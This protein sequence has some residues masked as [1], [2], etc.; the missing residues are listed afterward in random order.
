MNNLKTKSTS[1]SIYSQI[2][3]SGIPA[4]AVLLLIMYGIYSVLLPTVEMRYFNDKRETAKNLVETVY[5]GLVSRQKEV[6]AGTRT[7]KD[8]QYFAMQRIKM[9][10]YGKEKKDYFWLMDS[11]PSIIMHPYMTPQTIEQINAPS[12]NLR[13]D[14]FVKMKNAAMHKGGGFVDYQWQ[15]KDNPGLIVKK[16][17]YFMYFKPWDWI[18]GT[19]VYLDD[20]QNDLTALKS[21][22]LIVGGISASIASIL[23]FW[24]AWKSVNSSQ[25]NQ[26]FTEALREREQD[27]RITL[28]SIGD[29]VITTN[30][31]GIIQRFNRS[32]E[33]LTGWS[34]EKAIGLHIG[35]VLKIKRETQDKYCTNFTEIIAELELNSNTPS[36][37][38][39][40]SDL[41]N[42]NHIINTTFTYITAEDG[43]KLGVVVVLRDVSEAIIMQDKLQQSAKMDSIGKLA[44]GVAHD[45]NN[46][47][48]GIR[49]AAELLENSLSQGSP[50]KK[51]VEIINE[52]SSK[53]A[54]LTSKLLAFA[55]KNNF[56]TVK[57]NLHNCIKDAVDI[58]QHS[59]D[60]RIKINFAHKANYSMIYGDPSQLQNIFLNM[61]TNSRDAMPMGG[62]IRICSENINIDEDFCNESEFRLNPG[63]Y[64]KISFEDTGTGIAD[65][66][67]KRIFEPFYTTK[68]VGKGTGLGLSAVY[69]TV[70][71]HKGAITVKS[72]VGVGTTFSLLFPVIMEAAVSERILPKSKSQ[73]TGCILIIDDEPVM[74]KMAEALIASI[75]Y[76]TMVAENGLLGL[77][78][79]KE[80]SDKIDAII[81]DMVMPEMNGKDCFYELIKFNPQVKVII[82]SGFSKDASINELMDNGL[83]GFI[84]KPYSRQELCDL[85]TRVIFSEKKT[86]KNLR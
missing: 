62:E 43:T 9:M 21:S 38:L 11:K 73:Q 36:S 50:L 3:I 16:T 71:D 56:V 1:T 24:L 69:G 54:D 7:L 33:N 66:L 13:Y 41:N 35:S 53:A 20:M 57:T 4:L 85:L 32:A 25:K 37:R 72:E 39:I 60:K 19:G 77:N 15:W 83:S 27:L 70:K 29:A 67:Y 2:A 23:L 40:L 86:L 82:S 26:E 49:G 12:E 42:T 45:F 51:Y 74:R 78:V 14:L 47:L 18:I 34:S 48:G 63:K 28:E 65:D 30:P 64:I 80:N 75:G 46:M 8:A 79:Y 22:I 44:G 31:Y 10:R 84:S 61:G 76:S 58:L 6:E 81:L 59:I 68:D 17:S 55:R 5:S 52:A